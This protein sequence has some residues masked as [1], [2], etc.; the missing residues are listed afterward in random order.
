[1]SKKKS[2][3]LRW[4]KILGFELELLVGLDSGERSTYTPQENIIGRNV[5]IDTLRLDFA[6]QLV[7]NEVLSHSNKA[8]RDGFL[9]GF[10]V[11]QLL[12]G[13]PYVSW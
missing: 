9:N 3:Y 4:K 13:D 11:C 12:F 2:I 6:T 1:M 10:V 8:V 5:L 7:Q